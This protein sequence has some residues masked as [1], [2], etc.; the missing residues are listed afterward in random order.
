MTYDSQ[1]V[2][3]CDIKNST[4]DNK[5][6]IAYGCVLH[7]FK[8]SS[9]DVFKDVRKFKANFTAGPER[10]PS[11]LVKDTIF[12]LIEPLCYLYNLPNNTQFDFSWMLEI[13]K[14]HKF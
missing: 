10:T 14:N 12:C 3:T 6:S 8:V 2:T 9:K 1:N 5:C 13:R 7:L 11:F 4:Y